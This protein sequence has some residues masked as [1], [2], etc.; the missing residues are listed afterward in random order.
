MCKRRG[1]HKGMFI[2]WVERHSVIL[3]MALVVF[4][5]AVMTSN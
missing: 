5:V 4:V 2:N 1:Y 3:I